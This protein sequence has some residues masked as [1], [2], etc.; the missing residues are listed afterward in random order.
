[1]CPKLGRENQY[2]KT[3]FARNNAVDGEGFVSIFVETPSRE[4]L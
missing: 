2:Q 1:M 4:M 3:D